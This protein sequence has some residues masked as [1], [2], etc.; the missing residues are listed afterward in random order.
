MH[1]Q[2]FGH[3][4]CKKKDKAS[5]DTFVD[6]LE[7]KFIS[8][9]DHYGLA[10][11]SEERILYNLKKTKKIDIAVIF[12]S[13]PQIYFM[14][15]FFD[16]D[17]DKQ[18]PDELLKFTE[19]SRFLEINKI[20]KNDFVNLINLYQKYSITPDLLTNRFYGALIQIDQY[21]LSK[22]IKV[23][24]CPY[25]HKTIPS[26]FK[27]NSG[28]VDYSISYMQYNDIIDPD[29][30]EFLIDDKNN[31]ISNL[32]KCSYS[33]SDNAITTEGNEIISEKIS[34]HIYSLSKS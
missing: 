3:S 7:K 8:T 28:I 13:S 24:H 17:F 27:F 32:Y 15:G 33:K 10:M 14:P 30:G 29:S 19:D 11:C 21:C 1:I 20:T 18:T 2:F 23:I 22:N 5:V 25:H 4:I 12:H 6:I 26:W 31:T 34:N 16:R 9:S